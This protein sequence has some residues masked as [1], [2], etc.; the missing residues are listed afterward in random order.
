MSRLKKEAKYKSV[1]LVGRS[2]KPPEDYGRE[3]EG[4]MQVI[5]PK[6]WP[7]SK[8]IAFLKYMAERIR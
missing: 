4:D 6:E 5:Y 2:V 1:D 3:I 8:V 7:R